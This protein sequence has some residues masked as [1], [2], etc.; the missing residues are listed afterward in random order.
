MSLSPFVAFGAS[1][2]VYV[3]HKIIILVI[4][5]LYASPFVH[6]FQ[7][8]P[9]RIPYYGVITTPFLVY[10]NRVIPSRRR[11][12]AAYRLYMELLKRHAFSLASL[13]KGPNYQ[14]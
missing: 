10:Y 9:F 6:P 4:N 3:K 8:W 11:H 14:K 2:Y 1:L 13:V 12:P 5:I 7:I